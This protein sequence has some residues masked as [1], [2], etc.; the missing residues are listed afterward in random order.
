MNMVSKNKNLEN[1]RGK[2]NKGLNQMEKFM[3]LTK[4][5]NIFVHFLSLKKVTSIF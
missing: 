3:A 2:C 1:F 5:K 4:I